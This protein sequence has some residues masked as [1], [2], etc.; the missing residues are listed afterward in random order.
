M[1]SARFPKSGLIHLIWYFKN[2]YQRNRPR[3]S[4]ACRSHQPGEPI[5]KETM[6]PWNMTPDNPQFCQ[7]CFSHWLP[8]SN[9]H[10]YCMDL[11]RQF[12]RIPYSSTND[13]YLSKD[14]G[15]KTAQTILDSCSQMPY[16]ITDKIHPLTSTPPKISPSQVLVSDYALKELQAKTNKVINDVVWQEEELNKTLEIKIFKN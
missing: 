10:P 5:E 14:P 7:K 16:Y 13:P 4:A 6:Q 9:Q 15:Q 2:E 8:C 12:T 11:Q 1:T 3:A